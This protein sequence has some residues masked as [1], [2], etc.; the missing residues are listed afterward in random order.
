ML[1]AFS[2]V[3]AV[4]SGSVLVSAVTHPKHSV[5]LR[6]LCAVIEWCQWKWDYDMAKDLTAPVL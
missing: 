6:V 3:R 5:V 1:R 4:T 2:A